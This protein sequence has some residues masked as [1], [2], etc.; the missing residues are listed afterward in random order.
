MKVPFY[1]HTLQYNN[2][3]EEIDANMQEVIQSGSFVGGPVLARFEKQ[4]KEYFGT[5]YAIGVGNGTD[6]IWLTLMA[7]GIGAGDEVITHPNTFFATA[8]AAWITGAKVVFV[9]CDPKTK[10]IDPTKIEAAIT[11]KTK[12]I[13]PVHLYGQ[14]ADMPAIK[15]IADKHNLLIIEDDAQAIDGA[16]DT[17]KQGELSDAV[18]TSFIIQK[19]LGCF[20]DGGMVFT[21]NKA[22]ND[23]VRILRNHGSAERNKHS[24]G[25]NSRLDDIQ[26]AV[27][28]AKMN[29]ITEWTDTR[30]ERAKRYDAA[31]ADA[32]TI[33]LPYCTPGYRHVYHLYSIEVKDA[34]KR[35]DLQKFLNDNDIDAKNHYSIAIHQQEGYPWGKEAEIVGSIENAEINAASCVSLP[36]FPEITEEQIDFVASK[37]MEWDKANA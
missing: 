3:K 19:N 15:A 2:I 18:C 5:E 28:S 22:I 16:G 21:N 37:V 20:G 34:T 23:K 33:R 25:F 26:A 27:L 32:E 35:D 7:L 1:G 24:A 10:C 30:I 29:H 9:D 12:A 6:A 8:E 11:D 17:F 36:L 4:A 14:C 13:I 31:L